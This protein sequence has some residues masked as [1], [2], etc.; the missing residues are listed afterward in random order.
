MGLCLT[1]SALGTTGETETFT[2]SML[3]SSLVSIAT[4]RTL[5]A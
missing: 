1:T 5:R 2:I 4:T 3:R